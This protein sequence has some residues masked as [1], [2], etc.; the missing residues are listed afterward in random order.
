MVQIELVAAKTRRT[1]SRHVI[2]AEA[3]IVGAFAN[4]R[5]RMQQERG[6]WLYF[7]R[8]LFLFDG[9]RTY[10]LKPLHRLWWTESQA[11]ADADYLVA[12]A[13]APAGGDS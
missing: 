9:P 10:I 4:I 12:E 7:D 11:L 5:Q 8:N 6:Q 3:P 1:A 2:D 13:I